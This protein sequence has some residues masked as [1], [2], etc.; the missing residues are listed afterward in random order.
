MMCKTG[1]G[2]VADII[3]VHLYSIDV[4]G[5]AELQAICIQEHF[6]EDALRLCLYE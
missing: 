3:Y 4:S 6:W 2:T 5:E 1:S